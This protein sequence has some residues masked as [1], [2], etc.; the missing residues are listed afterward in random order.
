MAYTGNSI[1]DYLNSVGKDSSYSN[2]AKLAK[3]YGITNYSGTASQNTQLLNTLRSQGSNVPAY[4]S[5]P[6]TQQNMINPQSP[7]PTNNTYIP[8]ALDVNMAQTIAGLGSS[9][10]NNT[11]V[12]PATPVAPT[13]A[14]TNTA[15]ET[16]STGN[17]Q[18]D[19]MYAEMKKMLEQMYAAGGTINKKINLDDPAEMQKFYDQAE[20][21]LGPYYQSLFK[22]AKQDLYSYLDVSKKAYELKKA[23]TLDEFKQS[24]GTQREAAAGA[25]TAFSGARALGEKQLSD[26]ASRSLESLYNT[27]GYDIGGK[28][29]EYTN[30][31]GTD[32]GLT[33]ALPQYTAS[34][35]GRGL[36]SPERTTT[37]APEAGIVG[38][39]EYAARSTKKSYAQ[40]LATRASEYANATPM[41]TTPISPITSTTG[42]TLTQ[43]PNSTSTYTPIISA[44]DYQLKPGETIDAYNTRIK[45]LRGW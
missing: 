3:Q 29:R 13:Q 43:P 16:P 30:K 41:T 24:L 4:T 18:L 12:T 22:A 5:N 23:S 26:T 38:S 15:S 17:T 36:I 42:K 19:S 39:E 25:G 10:I 9:I 8:P 27:T 37:Y 14:T 34:A 21:E 28:I 31:Y 1:V 2:R 6:A 44:A 40:Q 33:T 11:P 35:A 32:T 45:Q 7:A 20:T